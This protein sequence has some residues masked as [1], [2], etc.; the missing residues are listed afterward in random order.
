MGIKHVL[1]FVKDG[2]NIKLNVPNLGK[3]V[4]LENADSNKGSA[5]SIVD[6]GSNF[7]VE[8]GNSANIIIKGDGQVM[9]TENNGAVNYW[10]GDTNKTWNIIPATEVEVSINEFA[11]ICLP[12][13]VEVENATA[14]AVENTTTEGYVMLVDKEDI[15]ANEGAILAGNGPATLTIID[16]ATA[17]W[18]ANKL[19]GTTVDTYIE[20][21]AYV[22][23]NGAN[24]IGLYGAKL[25][26]DADGNKVGEE[27]GTHFKNNANKAYLPM[28]A[29]AE[30]IK[31]YSFRFGEGTTGI[32]EVKTENGE[33]KAIYDLTGRKVEAITSP[34]IYIVNGK[35]VLVK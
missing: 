14:Y 20:G 12:F 30:G 10:W 9:R 32:E 21:D 22:L 24:G 15:A 6:G 25:N 34:G 19:E 4:Q 3:N 17:N 28:P 13:A 31:S 7:T 33:V 27:T 8:I 18:S 26:M 5:S 29:N 1:Q 16:E 2:E 11:S 23:A 35:K